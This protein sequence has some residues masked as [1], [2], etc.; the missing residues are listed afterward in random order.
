MTN[1]GM[2][3][4]NLGSALRNLSQGVNTYAVLGEKY[5]VLGYSKL[6]NPMSREELI[7]EG[8]F[9]N[10]FIE[11]RV[12]S[13]TKKAL[14]KADKALWFFFDQAE[15]INRGAAYLGAKAKGLS[16]GMS[17]TE[18]IEY[19]K[20]IVGKTQFNYDAI[21]QPVALGSD[22]MKTLFQF[23]SYTVKQLEFLTEMAK[24]KNVIGLIRYGLAGYLFVNTVGKAMG[25]TEAE[26]VPLYQNL[27]GERKNSLAPALNF[28]KEVAKATLDTPDKYGNKRDVK[29]KVSDIGKS[30]VGLIPAGSQI[31]KTYEGTKAIEE[32]GS[33]DKSGKLQFKQGESKAEKLQSI[34]FGKYAS[35]NAKDYFNKKVSTGDKELDKIIK[36]SSNK[37]KE[38]RE[39]L[40]KDV[41]EYQKLDYEEAVIKLKEL[42]KTDK[43]YAVKLR[44]KLREE[45]KKS[46]WSDI[47]KGINQLGVENGA[48]ADYVYQ[49][50]MAMPAEERNA[51]IKDLHD[52]KVISDIVL[53][54][55]KEL[56]NNR[57]IVN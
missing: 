36:E 41:E 28:P 11:D 53:K 5:T 33:F 3:G 43:E 16:K 2:L 10:N 46:T 27:T 15:K 1:R 34:L 47:D 49:K 31:K 13:S 23:Q 45:K 57:D 26:L 55:I 6:L 44:D 20:D 38:N 32:G 18:A 48:R 29:Q 50:M 9:N 39:R 40:S 30:L 8:V 51:Y 35:K 54:Q 12:L 4:G 21:D 25:M 52:R 42:A 56:H 19:A 24:D 22:I 7:R 37:D 14:Q 17:E